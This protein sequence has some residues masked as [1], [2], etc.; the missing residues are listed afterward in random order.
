MLK[1]ENLFMKMNF[2]QVQLNAL[3]QIYAKYFEQHIPVFRGA[4]FVAFWRKGY[5]YKTKTGVDAGHG[6]PGICI[7]DCDDDVLW[8]NFSDL[9][10]YM[11]KSAIISKIPPG[12]GMVPHVDRK[13]RP[14]VTI[15]FPIEGC[16]VDCTSHYYDLPKANTDMAQV[17]RS[18]PTP[19][20]SFAITDNAVMEN[21]REWHSVQNNSQVERVA[22]GWNML[23]EYSFAQAKTI[24]TDLGYIN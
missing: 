7:D 23:P 8:Q 20:Y 13:A 15:Y 12:K 24:L 11:A 10:P 18:N 4:G 14:E 3:G 21:V 6:N 17:N 2:S 22:F 5:V 1:E 16:T 9:L 19:L